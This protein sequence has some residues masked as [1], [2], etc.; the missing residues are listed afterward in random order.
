MTRLGLIT[1]AWLALAPRA[2]NGQEPLTL[3]RAVDT[4]LSRNAALHASRSAAS[5]SAAHVGEA[6]AGAF[7]R[8]SFSES[9][10]RGNQPVFVFGSLLSARQF[11]PANLALDALNHPDAT[12]FFRASLGVEQLLF[13][14]GRQ[15]S[16]TAGASI[17]HEMAIAATDQAA[18]ALIVATTETF[19]RVICADAAGRAAAAAVA[20]AEEDRT[21]AERRRDAGMVTDADVLSL[22]VHVADLRQR[23]I[24]AQGDA[25]VAR[26]ELNRLL[27]APIEQ[28]VQV[29]EPASGSA[30]ASP[31]PDIAAL[32]AEAEAARP[33]MRRAA[34]AARLAEVGREGARAALIPQVVTQ[35]AIEMNGTA[36]N[37]RASA[38]L[39]GGE[40]RWTLSTGGGE[41]ARIKAAA[42]GDARVRAERDTVRAAVHVEVISALRR[43]ETA[44]ARQALGHAAVEEARE[45]QR[46]TRNRFAAGLA[47][48][49]DVLRASTALLD[50]E[51]NQSSALVDSIVS[52][53]MLR[54]ALGRSR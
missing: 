15:R 44:R 16:A 24:Q 47:G 54:R 13:D 36:F 17:A 6:R 35:G 42:E 2:A 4:A 1:L 33:E 26:A 52:E 41:L 22:V 7:P 31:G 40:L 49:N 12:G 8:V 38:W 9:W 34:A 19:G 25:A 14:G 29:V 30:P 48:V 21:R 3:E 50:A 11:G 37:D 20:A 10:Q 32:L 39:V 53:A 46:I 18:A 28:A 5:E 45:S 27:G 43:V 51:R 23:E